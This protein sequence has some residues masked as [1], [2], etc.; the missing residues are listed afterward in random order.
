[1]RFVN[2]RRKTPPKVDR[3]YCLLHIA[4]QHQVNEILHGHPS[5][6]RLEPQPRFGTG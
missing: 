4:N 2:D 1:M 6:P 5:L 3:K